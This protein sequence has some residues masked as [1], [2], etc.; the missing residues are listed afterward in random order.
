MIY[1]LRRLSIKWADRHL[2]TAFFLTMLLFPISFNPRI[3]NPFNYGWLWSGGDISASFAGWNYFR[4]VPLFQ[5][6][7]SG[8]PLNGGLISQPIIFTDT[9]PLFAIPAKILG[10]FI[11][12]TF[13]FTGLQIFLSMFLAIYFSVKIFTLAGMQKRNAYLGAA[14]ISQAPF[15]MFRNQFEHYS[16]NLMWVAIASLFFYLRDT[17]ET[18]PT[19]RDLQWFVLIF[20][21]LTWMPY[22]VVFVICFWLPWLYRKI[23]R[24]KNRRIFLTRQVLGLLASSFAGLTIDGYWQNFGHS[25]ASGL[26]FYNANLLAFINPRVGQN[27][28]WSRIL[29]G[30]N[31]ATDGQYEGFAFL[32]TGAILLVAINLIVRFKGSREFLLKFWQEN[33]PLA[34]SMTAMLLWAT[35]GMF[36]ISQYVLL[37]VRFPRYIEATLSTFRSSGR[38]IIP[39]ALLLLVLI[40]L[41]TFQNFT[42][43]NITILLMISLVLTTFDQSPNIEIIKNHQSVKN[44][45]TKDQKFIRTILLKHEIN[46]VVF[47][48]PEI[49]AYDWKM[50][51]IGQSSLLGIPVNDG[52]IARVN[53]DKLQTSIEDAAS[54]FLNGP[55]RDKTLYVIYPSFNVRFKANVEVIQNKYK[56]YAFKDAQIIIG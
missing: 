17:D 49:S 23:H 22:L 5:W 13:Q 31:L 42:S 4:H 26:G 41:M 46:R 40:V 37:Q 33:W 21:A 18:K 53:Q 8:N 19:S 39:V 45:L 52:F 34:F 30:Y 44:T 51:I 28:D 27:Q 16:L 12:Q 15:L 6:P 50:I 36:S 38:F 14:I 10:M 54:E 20:V 1:Y 25:S 47:L 7:I 56:S 55:L 48:I 35:G 43:K 11:S 29:P 9:P 24:V 3:L 2:A 32:G